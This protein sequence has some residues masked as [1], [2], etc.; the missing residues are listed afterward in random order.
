MSMTFG[1]L[2]EGKPL[3]SENGLV[4][5]TYLRNRRLLN[6]M[7]WLGTSHLVELRYVPSHRSSHLRSKSTGLAS[8]LRR[9]RWGADQ[10]LTSKWPE[11][12]ELAAR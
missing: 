4:Q 2:S 9:D 12:V 10:A 11:K 8:C 3:R 1:R 7:I 5:P 6:P